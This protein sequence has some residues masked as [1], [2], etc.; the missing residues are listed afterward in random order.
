MSCIIREWQLKQFLDISTWLRQE[1]RIIIFVLSLIV[2]MDNEP[3]QHKQ[4]PR[5]LVDPKLT[6]WCPFFEDNVVPTSHNVQRCRKIAYKGNLTSDTELRKS[7][8]K[9]VVLKAKSIRQPSLKININRESSII[10]DQAMICTIPWYMTKIY[11]K[12]PI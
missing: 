8:Q 2:R 5:N 7:T 9:T 1:T 11:R 3:I 4:L 6:D 10:Y 12:Q